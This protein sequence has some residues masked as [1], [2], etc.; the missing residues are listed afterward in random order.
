MPAA[1]L[2]M[3]EIQLNGERRNVPEGQTVTELIEAM[4]IDLSR[5]AVELDRN[6]LRKADWST[7]RL[8]GG[9]EVEVV[10]FVGG[11]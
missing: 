10:H 1:S 6:I 8:H 11:G 9:E 2:K 3:V 7:T 4:G 5:V